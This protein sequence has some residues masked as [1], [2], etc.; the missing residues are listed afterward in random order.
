[1]W[2]YGT[3]T[4]WTRSDEVSIL[5]LMAYK[6]WAPSLAIE[7]WNLCGHSYW[8]AKIAL[9]RALMHRIVLTI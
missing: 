2:Y 3:T 6:M 9:M 1:M 5:R 8:S 7:K 4:V